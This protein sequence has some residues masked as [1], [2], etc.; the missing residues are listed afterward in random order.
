M[1]LR[2]QVSKEGEKGEEDMK[3]IQSMPAI[4]DNTQFRTSRSMV[5]GTLVSCV[6]RLSPHACPEDL[7]AGLQEFNE[8]FTADKFFLVSCVELVQHVRNVIDKCP[9]ILRWSNP[10]PNFD[11]ID[12]DVLA[13]IIAH[14]VTLEEKYNELH[15][16]EKR[17]RNTMSCIGKERGKRN[18]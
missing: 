17:Q 18:G 13:S 5:V 9:T 1:R 2:L 3:Q 8:A 11:F 7:V 6:V 10:K 14:A 15:G 16:F 4:W 12:L